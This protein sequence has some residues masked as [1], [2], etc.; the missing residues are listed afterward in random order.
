MLSSSMKFAPGGEPPQIYLHEVLFFVDQ[1]LPGIYD[2]SVA[3]TL[4]SSQQVSGFG[5]FEHPVTEKDE[6]PSKKGLYE[7]DDEDEDEDVEEELTEF[8]SRKELRNKLPSHGKYLETQFLEDEDVEEELTE[9]ISI[10]LEIW[11]GR[12]AKASGS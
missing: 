2:P 12:S 4:E 8:I 11:G 7:A 1:S 6:A 5:T 3:D 9:F 10:K